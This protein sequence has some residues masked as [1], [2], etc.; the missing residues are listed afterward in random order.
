MT[1]TEDERFEVGKPNLQ[2]V[3]TRNL[4]LL[5][6][7]RAG[8][9]ALFKEGAK[10]RANIAITDG[11]PD[12]AIVE[13]VFAAPERDGVMMLLSSPKFDPVIEGAMPPILA[14]RIDVS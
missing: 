6:I 7:E 4:A 1:D 2:E 13:S 11:V 14:I 8:F 3:R 9:M 12:D 10:W 5:F